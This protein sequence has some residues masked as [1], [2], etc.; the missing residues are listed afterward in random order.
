M[1]VHLLALLMGLFVVPILL[2]WGSG[3]VRRASPRAQQFFWGA[4]VGHCIAAVLAC[5]VAIVPPQ[6]WGPTDVARGVVGW[7]LL[8]LLPAALGVASLLTSPRS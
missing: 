8:L 6:A 2:L 3:R 4:A 1:S 7:W 5:V